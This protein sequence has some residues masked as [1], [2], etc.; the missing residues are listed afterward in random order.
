MYIIELRWRSGCCNL[1]IFCVCELRAVTGCVESERSP[2]LSSRSVASGPACLTFHPSGAEACRRRP[3]A[4]PCPRPTSHRSM[5]ER[6]ENVLSVLPALASVNKVL[7]GQNNWRLNFRVIYSILTG[8]VLCE[9]S[10]ENSIFQVV[11]WL[12]EGTVL[13]FVLDRVRRSWWA[14]INRGRVWVTVPS[15]YMESSPWWS[16][17]ANLIHRFWWC[18]SSHGK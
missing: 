9:I 15:T 13:F 1:I 3:S 12:S 7:R 17:C 2:V 10:A 8:I 5:R 14:G 4:M 6:V 11:L 16:C 18:P